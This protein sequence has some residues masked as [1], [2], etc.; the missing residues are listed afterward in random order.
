MPEGFSAFF[1][2]ITLV[3]S[4]FRRAAA[5]GIETKIFLPAYFTGM[6]T[7]SGSF[8][9]NATPGIDCLLVC[10]VARLLLAS[11]FFSLSFWGAFRA[12]ALCAAHDGIGLA[13]HLAEIKLAD[14]AGFSLI[15]PNDIFF[16]IFFFPQFST[17]RAVPCMGTAS[18]VQLHALQT[19]T[20]NIHPPRQYNVGSQCGHGI[21]V[22]NSFVRMYSLRYRPVYGSSCISDRA[23]SFRESR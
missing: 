3:F 4:A 16:S 13:A 21:H 19:R 20:S 12:I 11:I 10:F 22:S 14:L 6:R 17:L 7:L 5:I 8:S 1:H 15:F 23:F 18:N 2:Q 9:F